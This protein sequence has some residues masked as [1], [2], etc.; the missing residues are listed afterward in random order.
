M[1]VS[2]ANGPKALEAEN[3][4]LRPLLAEQVKDVSAER[5]RFGT[6]DQSTENQNLNR[7]TS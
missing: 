3:A 4:K 6:A 2:Q 5:R 1:K 7:A